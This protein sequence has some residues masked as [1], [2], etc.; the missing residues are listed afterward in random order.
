M[1]Y[2]FQSLTLYLHEIQIAKFEYTYFESLPATEESKGGNREIPHPI[3][4]FP[5]L[6][7]N[8]VYNA[9]SH[10]LELVVS[11]FYSQLGNQPSQMP[12]NVWLGS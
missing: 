9:A 5:T 6:L 7:K 11:N 8:P 3:T 12:M 10:T 1:F 2:L 4:P